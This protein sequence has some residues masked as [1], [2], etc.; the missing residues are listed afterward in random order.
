MA[1]VAI[2]MTAAEIVQHPEYPHVWWELK[3]EKKGLCPVAKGRG[4][5]FN[6]AYEVHGQGPIHLV[7]VM[8]LGTFK[9][10][11]QRQTKD[12]GHIQG[13]KYTCLIFDNRGVCESDKPMMRYS[14]SEM[15]KDT[16]ELIDF[17]GWKGK[18]E[19]HVIGVSMGGMITQEMGLLI[20]ERIGS[21]TLLSTGPRLFRTIPYFENL[22]NRINLFIPRAI[23]TQLANIK[24]NM[25]SDAWLSKP[26]DTEHVREPFPT[27]GD[28]YAAHEISKRSNPAYFTRTGFIAQ[29]IA[30]GWHYKSPSQIAELAD[31]IG[32]ERIQVIHGTADR[33]V[34][35]PHGKVLAEEM[36]GEE[37]GVTVR[38]VEGQGHIIPLEMRAEFNSWIIG[39]A[40]KGE[41]MNR[42]E[43]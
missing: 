41:R 20:P 17:I 9:S 43:R 36:G 12:I 2:P 40:E 11:W 23:D 7:W 22:R 37:R 10:S 32:R 21:M 34:T 27:N 4:G 3:P 6:I 26:D 28:R 31:R 35:F 13:D 29:A 42:E 30:A 33:M 16:I 19:L 14:T 38:F 39:H 25:C 8:G 24:R 18:R 1:A 5:P 15:A